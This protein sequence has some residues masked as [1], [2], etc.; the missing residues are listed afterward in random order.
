MS[1]AKKNSVLTFL[2]A[3]N[4]CLFKKLMKCP[5]V[6]TLEKKFE[7]LPRP[8]K[9]RNHLN[10]TVAPDFPDKSLSSFRNV[11][12]LCTVR[13][14][15]RRGFR[16]ITIQVFLLHLPHSTSNQPSLACMNHNKKPQL[17]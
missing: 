3:T 1:E 8:F 16:H 6:A 10:L 14:V 11:Y 15:L 17:A 7:V 2:K 13:G 4:D 12:E 5:L 9:F